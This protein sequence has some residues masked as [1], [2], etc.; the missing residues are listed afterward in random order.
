ML[1]VGLILAVSFLSPESFALLLIPMTIASF[2]FTG[3]CIVF[4]VLTKMFPSI[5]RSMVFFLSDCCQSQYMLPRTMAFYALFWRRQLNRLTGHNS[6]QLTLGSMGHAEYQE[7]QSLLHKSNTDA[8]EEHSTS[9]R[10]DSLLRNRRFRGGGDDDDVSV[11][12]QR[13]HRRFRTVPVENSKLPYVVEGEQHD[14][15]N[16]VEVRNLEA[17]LKQLSSQIS[18]LQHEL[19]MEKEKTAA[20]DSV[21][22]RLR[23]AEDERA[24]LNK[25]LEAETKKTKKLEE[26][27]NQLKMSSNVL[28]MEA[29]KECKDLASALKIER[30]RNGKLMETKNELSHRLEAE[31]INLKRIQQENSKIQKNYDAEKLLET[32]KKRIALFVEAQEKL[33]E[34]LESEKKMGDILA[35]KRLSSDPKKALEEKL[36]LVQQHMQSVEKA[37]TSTRLRLIKTQKLF[38]LERERAQY[39]EDEL[40]RMDEDFCTLREKNL[41]VTEIENSFKAKLEAM[42]EK[43]KAMNQI[44]EEQKICIAS[45]KEKQQQF[46]DLI[47]SVERLAHQTLNEEKARTQEMETKI[48]EIEV[49]NDRLSSE[50]TSKSEAFEGLSRQFDALTVKHTQVSDDLKSRQAEV[51]LKAK[52]CSK[53]EEDIS[54][55]SSLLEEA[56]TQLREG[57]EREVQLQ[58]S[59]ISKDQ[60]IET[61]QKKLIEMQQLE[62]RL[63]TTISELEVSLAKEK[64]EL[65]ASRT[66]VSNLEI[67]LQSMQQR[68]Q[69]RDDEIATLK[70][71]EMG[72]RDTVESQR[73]SLKEKETAMEDQS[74]QLRQTELALHREKTALVESND[75]V[76]SLESTGIELNQ[77]INALKKELDKEQTA[78]M[79]A[80]L[81]LKKSEQTF[82]QFRETARSNEAKL[83][84]QVSKLE[85]NLAA[86]EATIKGLESHNSDL[87]KKNKDLTAKLEIEQSSMKASKEHEE[88]LSKDLASLQED[89]ANSE[90]ECTSLESKVALLEGEAIKNRAATDKE[91]ADLELQ[92]GELQKNVTHLETR[93]KEETKHR[94]LVE[95]TF[96]SNKKDNEDKIAALQDEIKKL[97]ESLAKKESVLAYEKETLETLEAMYNEQ[98][99]KLE[100]TQQEKEKLEGDN[101]IMA[102]NVRAVLD[103][104]ENHKQT[105]GQRDAELKRLRINLDKTSK[106][107]NDEEAARKTLET[108]KAELLVKEEAAQKAIK[109]FEAALDKRDILIE[110]WQE[111]AN[112][113][114]TENSH[115]KDIVENHNTTIASLTKDRE[116]AESKEAHFKST[117]ANVT[118][119]LKDSMERISSLSDDIESLTNTRNRLEQ[120]LHEKESRCAELNLNIAAIRSELAAETKKS[121]DLSLKL[122][123]AQLEVRRLE[124]K[125]V[126]FESI[127]QCVVGQS[128]SVLRRDKV[129]VSVLEVLNRS[130]AEKGKEESLPKLQEFVGEL[131]RKTGLSFYDSH[132]RDYDT[133]L[134]VYNGPTTSGQGGIGMGR[135]IPLVPLVALPQKSSPR[136]SIPPQTSMFSMFGMRR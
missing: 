36:E 15:A 21:N 51:D 109:N 106:L 136:E 134:V 41:E 120:G 89:L 32:E 82:S 108:E 18:H 92:V 84:E 110:E 11:A 105:L 129:L 79:D 38:N 44:C 6:P 74:Q 59:N 62:E 131:S 27:Q 43:C 75:R 24:T 26:G 128:L 112:L 60:S 93:M 39:L 4:A 34:A 64:N 47:T 10:G 111:K 76:A 57:K 42:E 121:A 40:R 71:A 86:R 98:Q 103:E 127:K 8:T 113:A 91:I 90:E 115:L 16:T 31:A 48:K 49:Q 81:E 123:G 118:K 67:S 125:M 66:A 52:K 130:M 124:S 78:K 133:T 99:A 101:Q 116:E 37:S 61:S 80:E 30:Q 13:S 46:R 50:I 100:E 72:L 69:V 132:V 28:S 77:K 54:T 104:A 23:A 135:T 45:E 107:L 85:K 87:E 56:R 1:W 17:Q 68:M 96:Q 55:L 83:K 5:T 7:S 63:L 58:K 117:I 97:N 9:S 29:I 19:T 122:E 20:F 2:V 114:N 35:G 102:D 88:R 73:K 3:A 70:T 14:M 22:E 33:H 95:T 94:S 65:Q 119:E 25:L 126:D 53:L 12:S